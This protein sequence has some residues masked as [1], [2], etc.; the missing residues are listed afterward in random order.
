MNYS[1]KTT[2]DF[3]RNFKHLYK[4]YPSLKEDMFNFQKELLKNPAMGD[5]LGDNT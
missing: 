1:I 4:K 5:D 3:E 2:G